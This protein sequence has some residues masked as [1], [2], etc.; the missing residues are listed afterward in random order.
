[1]YAYKYSTINPTIVYNYNLPNKKQKIIQINNEVIK[2]RKKIPGYTTLDHTGSEVPVAKEVT[3]ILEM[4][5]KCA[6]EMQ[7]RD[8]MMFW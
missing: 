2:K 4:K 1:M 8:T 6:M 7:V 3:F 5:S